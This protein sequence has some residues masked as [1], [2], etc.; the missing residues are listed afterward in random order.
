MTAFS[1]LALDGDARA[2]G[3]AY[4]AAMGPRIRA[5]LADWLDVL[6]RAGV[7]DPSDYVAAMLRETDFKSAIAAHTP[8][9]LAEVE[10]IAEGAGAAADLVF[11]LQLLDEEWAYRGRRLEKCSGFAIVTAGGPTW[12]GQNM[13]L[14][15]YTNG[16]QALLRIGA[17]ARGPA[18][19]V[20][21]VPG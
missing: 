19:L 4:G 17:G 12:I 20:F 11:A 5:H 1:A 6:G 14:G 21:T 16:H 8:D 7:G 9:L 13:D 10:G 15:A 18:A 2:R 3:R